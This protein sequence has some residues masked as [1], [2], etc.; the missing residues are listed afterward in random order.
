MAGYGCRGFGGY[1]GSASLDD[2][3]ASKAEAGQ[4]LSKLYAWPST[5][6]HSMIWHSTID[7]YRSTLPMQ[8]G[9]DSFAAAITDPTTGV[10]IRP[11]ERI[12]SRIHRLLLRVRSRRLQ[13]QTR[14]Y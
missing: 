12:R 8:I 9:I 6:W 7:T 1:A 11:T 5:N 10:T 4:S 3:A 13:A 14:R 2:V